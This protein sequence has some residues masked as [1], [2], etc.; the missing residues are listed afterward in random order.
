[1]RSSLDYSKTSFRPSVVNQSIFKPGTSRFFNYRPAA[2]FL[3]TSWSLSQEPAG[4]SPMDQLVLESKISL[5]TSHGPA[6]PSLVDLLVRWSLSQGPVSP[7]IVNE[8]ILQSLFSWSFNQELAGPFL[9]DQL[10]LFSETIWSFIRVPA[11]PS[12]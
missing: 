1:M 3:W 8:L 6:G 11:C 2:F 5:S 4:L 9:E 12:L 7:S 10:V